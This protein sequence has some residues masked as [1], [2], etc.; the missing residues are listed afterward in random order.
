M[1]ERVKP[2]FAKQKNTLMILKTFFCSD[3]TKHYAAI[4]SDL[5]CTSRL[6]VVFR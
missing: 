2:Q 4:E 5:I 3:V 1:T 6:A